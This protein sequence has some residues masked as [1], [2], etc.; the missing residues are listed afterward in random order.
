MRFILIKKWRVKQSDE[1]GHVN[2]KNIV[3]NIC[4]LLSLRSGF[5]ETRSRAKSI[6]EILYFVEIYILNFILI[7]S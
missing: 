5:E 4:K 3:K 2:L 1:K 6:I 7:K